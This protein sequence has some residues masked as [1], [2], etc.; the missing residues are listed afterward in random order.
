M[1]FV[2][3]PSALVGE[4]NAAWHSV[5][6]EHAHLE[7]ARLG[8]HQTIVTVLELAV[9]RVR[10]MERDS[11]VPLA[12]FHLSHIPEA[13]VTSPRGRW[14]E[15]TEPRAGGAGIGE[16][17]RYAR[18]SVRFRPRRGYLDAPT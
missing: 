15:E 1:L 7:A 8:H 12:R 10:R 9:G 5:G 13:A 4:S 18:M 6:H 3:R 11:G 14:G 16:R 2:L 17:E